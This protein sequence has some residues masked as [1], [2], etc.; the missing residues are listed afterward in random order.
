MSSFTEQNRVLRECHFARLAKSTGTTRQFEFETTSQGAGRVLLSIHERPGEQIGSITWGGATVLSDYLISEGAASLLLSPL[1]RAAGP[2]RALRCLE[3]GAGTGLVGLLASAALGAAVVST[4]TA[5]LLPLLRANQDAN[6][7][8]LGVG[9]VAC[10]ELAW[11]SDAKSETAVT[12]ALAALAAADGGSS[13]G[14][15]ENSGG[16]VDVLLAADVVYS[17]S[18]AHLL[19]STLA[20]LWRVSPAAPLLLSYRRRDVQ[21]EHLF[22]GT[23]RERGAK[24]ALLAG[25]GVAADGPTCLPEAAGAAGG[26]VVLCITT[27]L[28]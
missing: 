19:L 3:L 24:I 7:A 6:R 12:A 15:E 2:A 8:A 20:D 16:G 27:A 18:T 4:D 23:L 17:V 13:V 22:F 11:G 14:S 28:P 10:S 5:D 21:A 26:D 9:T 25:A 1:E